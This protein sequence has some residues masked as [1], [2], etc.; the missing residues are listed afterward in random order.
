MRTLRVLATAAWLISAW[1]AQTTGQELEPRAYSPSPVGTTF[2]GVSAT[3]SAGGVFTD[4]S[5]PITDVDATVGVLGLAAGH[6]V[7]I[8]GRQVLLFALLPVVWG[9]AAGD[10][11][12]DRREVS[13]R[14][15]GDMRARVSIILAGAPAMT[16]A[17]FARRPRRTIVGASVTVAPPSGQYDPTKLVNLG[18]NRWAIKPEIG[19]SVPAGR[20]TLD[21]YASVWWF[22]DNAQYYPGANLRE[23][24]PVL[25]L[26]GH[27]SRTF[28][29]RSWI[30]A[31]LTWYRGGTTRINGVSR[32]DLQ[33]NTRLGATW[34]LPVG[35]R[36]SVKVAYSAG[37]TTRIGADFKTIAVAWQMVFF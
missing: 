19:V 30:A 29:R 13:R 24:A 17:E 12:E 23:Q 7:G 27:V 14:G 20:W 5:A 33:Q 1:P 3:R 15:L 25:A 9:E 11:G 26:Q 16:L 32:E 31:N 21:G 2:I 22:S 34:S 6:T 35:A 18:A 28:G 8:G 10:V 37:A 36:Q 4:P